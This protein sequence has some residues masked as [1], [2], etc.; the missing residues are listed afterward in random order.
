MKTIFVVEMSVYFS[1]VSIFIFV[2]SLT[3]C[4]TKFL[5]FLFQ[6]TLRCPCFT[7]ENDI[8]IKLFF[9]YLWKI[10]YPSYV[11]GVYSF[12]SKYYYYDI[13]KYYMQLHQNI[14]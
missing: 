9:V 2:D 6:A 14:W 5:L 11:C 8:F 13:L 1:A 7:D 12:I 10:K 3:E 4:F